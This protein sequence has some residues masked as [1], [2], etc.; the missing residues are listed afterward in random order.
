[1]QVSAVVLPIYKEIASSARPSSCGRYG[2]I[3]EIAFVLRIKKLVQIQ[4]RFTLV[5]FY[6]TTENLVAAFRTK[7][8]GFF[9]SNPLLGAD[10]F[11]MGD[12]P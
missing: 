3:I 6:N 1:M 11:S 4:L 7:I 8:T 9:I 2:V 12:R 10:F 5:A